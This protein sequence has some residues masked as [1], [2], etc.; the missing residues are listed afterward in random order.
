MGIYLPPDN[1]LYGESFFGRN[2]WFV[3]STGVCGFIVLEVVLFWVVLVG[4]GSVLLR[5]WS[6]GRC[7]FLFV[8]VKLWKCG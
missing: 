3:L 6:N 1:A 5:V 7:A 8:Y 2:G 4:L